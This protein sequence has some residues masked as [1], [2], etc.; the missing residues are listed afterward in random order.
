M[1]VPSLGKCGSVLRQRRAPLSGDDGN[2]YTDRLVVTV[3][4]AIG[5]FFVRTISYN[6][7]IIINKFT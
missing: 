1:V 6:L 2:K 4:Y 5:I 3:F 7:S